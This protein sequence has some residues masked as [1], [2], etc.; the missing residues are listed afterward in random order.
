MPQPL[1]ENRTGPAAGLDLPSWET[2]ATELALPE[3][4]LHVW[5]FRLPSYVEAPPRAPLSPDEVARAERIRSPDLRQRFVS[6]RSGLRRVLALYR[7]CSPREIRFR[8]GNH[9]KPEIDETELSFDFNLA[10]AGD[11]G[12]VAVSARGPVGIDL[13]RIAPRPHLHAIA[14]RMFPPAVLDRLRHLPDDALVFE[15]LR[16]WTA[17]EARTKY[18]GHGLFRAPR[19]APPELRIQ[20]FLAQADFIAA[21]ASKPVPAT[22][23]RLRY[24]E[25]APVLD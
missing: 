20:H 16:E 25:L 3:S 10:H 12:L 15:F 4:E 8:Y 24:L 13:E 14:A 7:R 9:G 18:L 23:P 19:A 21:L 5:K 1:A 6:A 11:L 22:L 17:L 2:P